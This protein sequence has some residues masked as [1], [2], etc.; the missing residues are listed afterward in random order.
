MPS[1]IYDEASMPNTERLTWSGVALHA[2]GLPGYSSSHGLRASAAR[3]LLLAVR[4]HDHRHAG[5]HRRQP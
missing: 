4:H 1:S 3:L 5:D 2:G